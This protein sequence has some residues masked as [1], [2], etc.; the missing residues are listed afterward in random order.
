MVVVKLLISFHPTNET[1]ITLAHARR[2][3]GVNISNKA[4]YPYVTEPKSGL[5]SPIKLS[6]EP[7]SS[8]TSLLFL[9]GSNFFTRASCNCYSDKEIHTETRYLS[10]SFIIQVHFEF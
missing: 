1:H 2:N 3:R 10:L 9:R 6:V 7:N 8:Q 4:K 5:T